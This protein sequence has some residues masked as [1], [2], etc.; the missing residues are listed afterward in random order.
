MSIRTCETCDHMVVD[1]QVPFCPMCRVAELENNLTFA[2]ESARIA[3][4]RARVAEA[5]V[6]DLLKER[7]FW[8]EQDRPMA[9][10]GK[11]PGTCANTSDADGGTSR[12][13]SLA[14]RVPV[15]ASFGHR[16]SEACACVCWRCIQGK[17][18]H[19]GCEYQCSL[20]ERKTVWRNKHKKSLLDQTP[21]ELASGWEEGQR[22]NEAWKEGL[23]LAEQVEQLDGEN[24]DLRKELCEARSALAARTETPLPRDAAGRTSVDIMARWIVDNQPRGGG[25][26]ACKQCYPET[27][28]GS[29]TF[30]CGF[31]LA[32]AHEA[33]RTGGEGT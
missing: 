4:D 31:H 7:A 22:T 29:G 17:P 16:P 24:A 18:D 10:V 5:R 20:K 6:A 25:D 32:K 28:L 33:T 15:S 26:H 9:S 3:S 12:A 21:E 8:K 27:Y 19:A 14:D 2:N 30:V 11:T 1:N 13:S 23:S